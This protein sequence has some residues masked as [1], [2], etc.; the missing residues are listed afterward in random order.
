MAGTPGIN[1]IERGFRLW[2]DD[3]GGTARDL[4]ASLI[5]GTVS[6]GGKTLDEVDMTGV[7]N[8]IR[9]ALGGHA[10]APV[11]AQFNMD[12]TATTGSFTVLKGMYGSIGTLTLQYG[13]LGNAP[14][15]GDPEWEGEYVL[16]DASVTQSG[17]KMIVNATWAPAAGQTDPAWGTVA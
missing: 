11:T 15:T 8:A 1:K 5:P 2:F 3:S 9:H 14:D 13:S 6:G 4:S 17:G 7:S 12:D 10:S 16:L